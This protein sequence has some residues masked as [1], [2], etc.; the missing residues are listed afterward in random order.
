MVYGQR[1][2]THTGRRSTTLR[3]AS[4]ECSGVRLRVVLTECKIAPM[5]FALF[6]KISPQRL[7]NWFS[8][9]IPHS[10]LDKVARL[11]SVNAQWLE[12]GAGKKFPA[13]SE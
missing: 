2:E 8:R 7:T 11:L 6:L 12:T 13:T 9:G 10:Q 4:A 1:K 5:D 3:A